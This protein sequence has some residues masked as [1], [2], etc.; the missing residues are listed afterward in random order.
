MCL[1]FPLLLYT[2]THI[3]TLLPTHHTTHTLFSYTWFTLDTLEEA[4]QKVQKLVK[5]REMALLKETK[6]QEKN[7]ELRKAFAQQA[8][9]F[10]SWLTSVRYKHVQIHAHIYI[11]Y[12]FSSWAIVFA[13]SKLCL[14]FEHIIRKALITKSY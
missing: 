5:E 12:P 3:C 13:T 1:I 7:D 2:H 11:K 4:W 9:S 8:N 6:R 14:G 10:H